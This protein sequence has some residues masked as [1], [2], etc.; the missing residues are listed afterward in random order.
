VTTGSGASVTGAVHMANTICYLTA[1]TY[2]PYS[3]AL[4]FLTVMACQ[5]NEHTGE[6]SVP[7]REFNHSMPASPIELK[8]PL[9]DLNLNPGRQE[10]S[11]HQALWSING[12]LTH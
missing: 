1:S 5:F 8:N 7:V 10:P 11:A 9:P 4:L 2:Y 6:P 12:G 3:Q